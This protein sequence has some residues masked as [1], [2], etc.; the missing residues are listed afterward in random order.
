M[1][2]K[3]SDDRRHVDRRAEDVEESPAP[4]VPGAHGSLYRAVRRLSTPDN[5]TLA[6]A[7]GT[8]ERMPAESLELLLAAGHIEAVTEPDHG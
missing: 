4:I 1:I 8:C 3:P 6:E 7:G 2:N 5:V